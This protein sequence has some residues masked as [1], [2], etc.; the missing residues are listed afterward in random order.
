MENEFRRA[1]EVL[2]LSHDTQKKAVSLSF[3]GEGKVKATIATDKLENI[4]KISSQVGIATQEQAEGSRQIV[5]SVEKMND[6]T[7]LVSHATAEQ[8]K[9]GE[10]VVRAME[11]ISEIARDNLATVQE[12]S[13]ATANLA[14][15]AENLARLVSVFRIQ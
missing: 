5:H 6:M 15:Q 12:M 11:N 10:L 3:A 9:G 14:Q 8:K 7:Q 1:L 4:N 2:A 13:K